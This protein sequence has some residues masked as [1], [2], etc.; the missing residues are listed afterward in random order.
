MAIT[1][2][3]ASSGLYMVAESIDYG[4][5]GSIINA[6]KKAEIEAGK[7]IIDLRI[8]WPSD[9][10]AK[11]PHGEG[12]ILSAVY[13]SDDV[14]P[15]YSKLKEHMLDKIGKRIDSIF[16]CEPTWARVGLKIRKKLIHEIKGKEFTAK[17][18]AEA[19]A[20]DR[21]KLVSRLILPA[22]QDGVDIYCE[23]NFCSSVVYQ[24]SMDNPLSIDEVMAIPGNAFCAENAPHLYIICDLSAETAMERKNS[25]VRQKDDKCMFEVPE[26]LRRIEGKYRSGELKA[27][28]NSHGSMVAYVNTD[29]PT[30]ASDTISA[31]LKIRESFMEGNLSD[32]KKFNYQA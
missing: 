24:S 6:I 28:L 27:L 9:E 21:Q 17:D 14:I 20:E 26:F 4:G 8:L 15:E 19:Y 12:N 23:R 11:I 25:N 5:K 30:E 2:Y 13:G 3:D 31:A 1:T 22:I 18:V 7:T 10:D 29:K 16:T 32:G